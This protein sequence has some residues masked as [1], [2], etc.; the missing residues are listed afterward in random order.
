MA[1]KLNVVVTATRPGRVGPT[2]GRWF[3][4]VAR[5][6]GAFEPTLVD[7]AEFDLPVFDEPHHPRMAKYENAHTKAWSESCKAADAFVF[8]MPEY[9]YF[10]PA[11]FVNAMTYLS[12][13]WAYKVAGFVSYANVS[14][15]TRAVQIAKGL[16]ANLKMVTP[17][18]GV[19]IPSF[20]SLLDGNKE[21]MPNDLHRASAK[22]MLDEMLKWDNALRTLRG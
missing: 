18:E 16:C 17:P 8:V 9:N 4:N 10:P 22:T 12:Q 2:F 19:P 21:F 20:P 11:A 13:E 14:G 3:T 6:H 1:P 15:G 5:E 7:L